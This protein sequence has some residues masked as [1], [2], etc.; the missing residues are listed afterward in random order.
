MSRWLVV[1]AALIAAL[2]IAVGT[3]AALA[4]V[5]AN[6]RGGQ[7]VVLKTATPG[8]LERAGVHLTS[9][10]VP[11]GCGL[12]LR[13]P[14]CPVAQS[15]AEAAAVKMLG[16]SAQAR[17]RETVLARVDIAAQ[18]GLAP[19]IHGLDWVVAV[20]RTLPAAAMMCVH[21]MPVS[22]GPVPLPACGTLRYL[23]FVDASTGAPT[24]MM[25]RP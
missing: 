15:T 16:S 11:P 14:G 13:L 25:G 24:R 3:G 1:V 10:A 18:S 21:P 23:V 20:D 4:Q 17:V 22:S 19:P 6:T 7:P 8:A 2:V 9:A 12:P 5:T